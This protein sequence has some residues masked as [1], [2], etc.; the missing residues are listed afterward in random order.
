MIEQMYTV[1]MNDAQ[2]AQFYGQYEAVR[3]DEMVGVLLALLLGTFGAH[4]FYLRRNGLGILYAVFCWTG[5]PSL[6]S[7][8]ECFFMPGRVR[9]YNMMQASMIA[10]AVMGGYP[11]VNVYVQPA[12][13]GSASGV[14]KSCGG[15]VNAGAVYCPHCGVAVMA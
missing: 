12:A 10:G 4:H 9:E 2:R 6:V 8:I 11:A 7:F 15:A 13:M 14:C 1:Y 5:I 3:K